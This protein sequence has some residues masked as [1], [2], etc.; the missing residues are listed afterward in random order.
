MLTLNKEQLH[1]IDAVISHALHS[2]QIVQTA[3]LKSSWG[4]SQCTSLAKDAC[5][6]PCM[7]SSSIVLLSCGKDTYTPPQL[8]EIHESHANG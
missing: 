1:P 7:C 3:P 4:S 2:F 6:C 5:H 8:R